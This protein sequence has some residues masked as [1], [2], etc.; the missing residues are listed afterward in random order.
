MMMMMI[1]FNVLGGVEGS[2]QYK[3]LRVEEATFDC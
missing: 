2:L 1:Y 3:S